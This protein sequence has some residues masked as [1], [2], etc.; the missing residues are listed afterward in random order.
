MI[1]VD[2][3]V[4]VY[5]MIEGEKTEMAQRTYRQDSAWFIPPLWRH[6]L[7][8]VLTTFVR[9]T[10]SATDATAAST[11]AAI[12]FATRSVTTAVV[13]VAGAIDRSVLTAMG[14]LAAQTGR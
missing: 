4:I 11:T 2:T 12:T 7:L 6:E 9:L 14:T 1:V 5:L 13:Y 3:N 8:N 10:S